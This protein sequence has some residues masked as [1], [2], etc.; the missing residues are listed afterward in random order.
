MYPWIVVFNTGFHWLVPHCSWWPRPVPKISQSA[1]NL[2]TMIR[3]SRDSRRLVLVAHS[4]SCPQPNFSTSQLQNMSQVG[5]QTHMPSCFFPEYIHN[6]ELLPH[7]IGPLPDDNLATAPAGLFG[8]PCSLT[9][10]TARSQEPAAFND[11][12]HGCAM[13]MSH[14]AAPARTVLPSVLLT[15]PTTTTTAERRRRTLQTQNVTPRE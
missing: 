2:S 12:T 13:C 11:G 14:L 8:Q 10:C 9:V 15:W 4:G 6:E 7:R 5:R 3:R 1:D